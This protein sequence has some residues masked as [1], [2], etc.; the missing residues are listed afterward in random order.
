V[1]AERFRRAGQAEIARWR[2]GRPGPILLTLA[3]LVPRKGIDT[4][5]RALPLMLPQHPELHCLV[6][7]AG[8]DRER[9]T[10]LAA[11]LGVSAHVTFLGR[12]EDPDLRGL[13]SAAD[14]FALLSR[15]DAAGTDVEGFGLVLLE[16]QAAGTPVASTRDGGMPDAFVPGRTGILVD[17]LD[18]SD[19][20]AQASALLADPQR[21]RAMSEAALAFART[22]SWER[23]ARFVLEA[24]EAR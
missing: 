19:F 23:S 3:R 15:S 17:A 18:P 11:E 21:K 1:D 24:F 22:Q 7:G 4:L 8:P 10:A 5:L 12:V 2:G 6:A 9:L 20:A 16:A 13:F 14:L